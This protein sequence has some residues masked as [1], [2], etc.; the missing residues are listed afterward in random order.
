MTLST[1][2]PYS[3]SFERID[4]HSSD[5]RSLQ[6]GEILVTPKPSHQGGGAIAR[7][8]LPRSRYY[9]WEQL[10]N[11]PRWREYFPDL[12][13]SELL[14]ASASAPTTSK[15]LYQV[16]TKNFILL[17]IQV[18]IYLK[19]IEVPQQQIQ[20]RLE[21]GSFSSFSADLSLQ[22]WQEGTLLTYAVQAVPTI[23]IPQMFLQQALQLELPANM[24]QMRR[25]LAY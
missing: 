24:R 20:F 3:S 13:R 19:V 12:T 25:V 16:G 7:M 5:A 9:Y 4:T 1:Q 14:P 21:K 11:Y 8:Y 15:R 22:D 17:S 18:E 23:P 6:K 10:T 2:F